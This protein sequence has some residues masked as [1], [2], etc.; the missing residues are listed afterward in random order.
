M[1]HREARDASRSATKGD[2]KFTSI[3]DR[4]QND[5]IYR[6]SQFVHNWSDA[7]V[8]YLDH[9]VHFSI[10]H[11]ATQ[12]QRKKICT[13]FTDAVSTS[14]AETRVG[15]SERKNNEKRE[16]LALFIQDWSFTC[17]GT[18][19]GRAQIGQTISQKN[20]IS[21]PAGVRLHG[22]RAG[23]DGTTTVGRTISGQSNDEWNNLELAFS[24]KS[25]KHSGR[26]CH[27][28][29][30]DKLSVV[31]V[32]QRVWPHISHC[33][34]FWLLLSLSFALSQKQQQWVRREV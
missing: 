21:R 23:R 9:T 7:W 25:H 28:T 17:K 32:N 11:N 1:H 4:W 18:L 12:Q 15:R 8:R 31:T 22:L 5:A 2:R 27:P 14:I 6:H 20:I 10:Y 24:K 26:W 33:S 3:W 34:I 30:N 29:H 13:Y 19:N 16:K